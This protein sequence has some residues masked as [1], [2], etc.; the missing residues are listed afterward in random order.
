MTLRYKGRGCLRGVYRE[1][2]APHT[3]DFCETGVWEAEN[4]LYALLCFVS[5]S[6]TFTPALVRWHA[7]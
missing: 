7:L 2:E 5:L 1:K 4:F 3:P 6:G